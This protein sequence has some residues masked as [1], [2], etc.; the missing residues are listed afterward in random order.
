MRVY[1]LRE[2]GLFGAVSGGTAGSAEINVDGK[3]V[4]TVVMGSYFFV[5]RP[6]RSYKISS[7]TTL[8]S[9]YESEVQLEAGQT[10]YFGIGRPR[11]G[12]LLIDAAAGSSGQQL[13]STSPLM[14]GFSAAALFRL[15]PAAGAAAIAQL[16]A[17]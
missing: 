17:L 12:G 9:A 10:Y 5:D 13:P 2:Q 14:A 11:G 8:S 7:G 16:K 4:G 1:F 6:P 3:V 15:E